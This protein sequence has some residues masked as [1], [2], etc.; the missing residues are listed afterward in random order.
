MSNIINFGSLY[1]GK[2]PVPIGTQYTPQSAIS[3]GNTAAGKEI[4]W[5]VVNG[6]L[7]ADRCILYNVSWTDLD[8]N[9]LALGTPVFIDGVWYQARLLRMSY[10]EEPPNEWDDALDVVGEDDQ[11]WHWKNNFFWGQE[12]GHS[13]DDEC[14]FRGFYTARAWNYYEG[15]ARSDNTGFRPVLVPANTDMEK[16]KEG[17]ELVAWGGQSMVRGRLVQMSDYD[18]ILSDWSGMSAEAV[19]ENY[20]ATALPNQ[21]LVIDRS[22]LFGV[23]K[24]AVGRKDA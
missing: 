20:F 7:I 23:Q 21:M 12:I 10:D 16:I 3:I 8:E 6:M 13:M 19:R 4:S 9:G 22:C 1:L 11:I 2:L 24:I 14:V 5:V 17:A 18:L 15:F